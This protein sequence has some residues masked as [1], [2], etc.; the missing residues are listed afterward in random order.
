MA[1][2]AEP[3]VDRRRFTSLRSLQCVERLW[4]TQQIA[5]RRRTDFQARVQNIRPV[6]EREFD[7]KFHK[8]EF[9]GF[10]KKLTKPV[11]NMK[12]RNI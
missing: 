5:Q 10:S 12:G 9:L 7:Q 2:P 6:G 8:T 1:A 3:A 11:R 4:R